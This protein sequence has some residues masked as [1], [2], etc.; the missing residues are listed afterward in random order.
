MGPKM[1]RAEQAVALGL[2][3]AVVDGLRLLDLAVRTTTEVFSG[4]AIDILIWSNT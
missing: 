1:P 4:L 2:E 3:G